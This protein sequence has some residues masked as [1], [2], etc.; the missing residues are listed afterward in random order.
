M[1]VVALTDD[2]QS[3]LDLGGSALLILLDLTAAFDIV[4]HGLLA[5]RLANVGIQGLALKW[6]RSFL[7]GRGQRVALG[8]SISEWWALDC[9]VPQGAILSLML[10]NIYMHPLAQ[11]VRRFGLVAINMQMTPSS[12]C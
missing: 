11:L 3:Q 1:A 5:H 9:G 2:L 6:L 12:F 7:Q 8:E 10:F 4:D